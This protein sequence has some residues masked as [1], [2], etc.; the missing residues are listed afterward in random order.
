[1]GRLWDNCLTV[2]NEVF[3][4]CLKQHCKVRPQ[5]P[6][7]C[8]TIAPRAP[9]SAQ[10]LKSHFGLT[11]HGA[12]IVLRQVFKGDTRWDVV[13]FIAS[14]RFIGVAT[15]GTFVVIH[16]ASKVNSFMG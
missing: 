5:L 15:D 2:V 7:H 13:H 6:H 10:L 9:L 3:D 4:F 14:F 12:F 1:M 16:I 8:P 11:A